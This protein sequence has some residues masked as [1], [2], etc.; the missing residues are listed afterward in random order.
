M[1]E[2]SSESDYEAPSA[3]ELDVGGLPLATSAGFVSD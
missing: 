2:K 1:T 3:E